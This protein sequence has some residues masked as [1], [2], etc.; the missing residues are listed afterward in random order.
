MSESDPND[1]FFMAGETPGAWLHLTGD[2]WVAPEDILSDQVNN[3]T[4]TGERTRIGRS[5]D[6]VDT[7]PP[8]SPPRVPLPT[9]KD[10]SDV[11]SDT[12]PPPLLSPPSR[13]ESKI[14]KSYNEAG[15]RARRSQG[16]IIRAAS[17]SKPR[18]VRTY[19]KTSHSPGPSQLPAI[20]G[21]REFGQRIPGFGDN[22]RAQQILKARP[23]NAVRTGT[24]TRGK[25]LPSIANSRE[26]TPLEMNDPKG[27]VNVHMEKQRSQ[28]SQSSSPECPLTPV[29][30]DLGALAMIAALPDPVTGTPS[31]KLKSGALM[32]IL[33]PEQTCWQRASYLPGPIRLE[34]SFLPASASALTDID[35]LQ[36]PISFGHGRTASDDAVLDDIVDFFI[37]FGLLDLE[38][39]AWSPETP[40]P[41]L[42][43]PLVSSTAPA[44]GV[45]GRPGSF[46]SSDGSGPYTRDPR[47]SYSSSRESYYESEYYLGERTPSPYFS[48]RPV[49]TLPPLPLSQARRSS[50]QSTTS[51]GRP[52]QGK[53]SRPAGAQK[54]TLRRLIAQAS[55]IV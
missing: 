10:D 51:T 53:R 43:T 35:L 27:L 39:P 23:L 38:P 17:K 33:T 4:L 13:K 3:L 8:Y 52:R 2:P 41:S 9:P 44:F 36:N 37:S 32:A 26:P 31:V 42:L 18:V 15:K 11:E 6:S 29:E 7:L 34:S 46:A 12:L 49:S 30:M 22:Q 54:L 14:V 45:M 16:G 50:M 25:N 20:N 55:S 48:G 19:G 28:W 24:E 40:K 47:I 1:E 5:R 21:F